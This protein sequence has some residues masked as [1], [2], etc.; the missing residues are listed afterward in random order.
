M[1]SRYV[2][3]FRP[4][5]A[6][7]SKMRAAYDACVA[8]DLD[9]PKEVDAF[10]NGEAPDASGVK[11]D[12]TEHTCCAEYNDDMIDGFEIDLKKLPKDIT[13]IRFYTSY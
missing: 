10:F 4:P 12:L 1:S 2:V 3:G 13:I 8:A 6:K 7:W 5:G 11:V 9:I